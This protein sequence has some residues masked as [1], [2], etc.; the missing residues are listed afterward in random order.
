MALSQVGV[1]DRRGG[2]LGSSR[3]VGGT[4]LAQAVARQVDPVG[5]VDEAV[6]HGIGQG[7]GADHLVPAVDWHLAGDQH[8]SGVVAVLDDLEQ[9]TGLLGRQRL[10]SPVVEDQ[11]LGA[12]EL[13]EQ[14]GIAAVAARQAERREQARHAI[15]QDR[16]VLPAGLLAERAGEPAFADT[17]RPGDHQ[18][19][20]A[21]DPVAAGRA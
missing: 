16:Q 20:P 2:R 9:V 8:R 21:A 19:A 1:E 10:R 5:V 3:V 4:V 18:V 12:R 13:L 7:R 17:A 14:L 11:Q 15:V 6:E